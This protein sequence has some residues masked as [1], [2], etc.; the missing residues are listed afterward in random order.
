MAYFFSLQLFDKRRDHVGASGLS[1]MLDR[2]GVRSLAGSCGL[3]GDS[4]GSPE[5]S[6]RDADDPPEVK[7]DPARG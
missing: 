2:T 1:S 3:L 5:L 6:R 4:C 7:A